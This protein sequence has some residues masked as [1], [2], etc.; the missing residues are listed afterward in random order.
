IPPNLQPSARLGDVVV[1]SGH[2]LEQ[3][4]A[5]RILHPRLA[6]PLSVAPVANGVSADE[7]RFTLPNDPTV[8]PA[9]RCA[10]A[11]VAESAGAPDRFSNGAELAVAPIVSNP[12]AARDGAGVVTVR[13]DCRPDVVENQSVFLLLTDTQI[14]L[15][16]VGSATGNLAFTSSSL[17]P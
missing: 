12:A 6:G 8:L 16:G 15:G 17:A 10:V 9:G 3:T 14:G 13:L 7:G 4:T 11:A 1:L 2:H 5:V